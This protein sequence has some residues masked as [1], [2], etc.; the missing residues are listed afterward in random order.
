M[1]TGTNPVAAAWRRISNIGT[2]QLP[3][4]RREPVAITNQFVVIALF[5][6]VAN[7]LS[8]AGYDAAVLKP[9]IAVNLAGVVL[10]FGVFLLNHWRRHVAASALGLV[11]PMYQIALAT[12][13][14]SRDCG[15]HFYLLAPSV[16]AVL[17]FRDARPTYRWMFLLF[18]TLEMVLL[19]QLVTYDVALVQISPDALEFKFGTSVVGV[20]LMLFFT[21][22]LFHRRVDKQRR[23]LER[24]NN[25]IEQLANTDDLTQL[26]NRRRLVSELQ[27]QLGHGS[28]YTYVVALGD[29]DHFKQFN[30]R[31][32]HS[33]GDRVL[34]EVANCLESTV[35]DTDIVGRWGG[36]EFIFVF[37]ATALNDAKAVLER[38]RVAVAD[39]RFEVDG[40]EHSLTISIGATEVDSS[41]SYDEAV[42]QAD[43]ALYES[44]GSGRNRLSVA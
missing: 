1:S 18:P 25:R 23:E 20:S 5:I 16:L 43:I 33:V 4:T 27:N 40:E 21:S 17:F 3:P 8:Y 42:R 15:T 31:F 32:G 7:L 29:I 9:V 24:A 14:L 35:R 44:K 28:G 2:S 38:V 10:Y 36:E 41:M 39:H 12:L 26:P 13:V 30:D 34:R 19:H 37:P 11:V 6:T 22:Y